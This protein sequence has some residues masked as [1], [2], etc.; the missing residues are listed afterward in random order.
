MYIFFVHATSSERTDYRPKPNTADE[1]HLE[2]VIRIFFPSG[3]RSNILPFTQQQLT[4]I[5]HQNLILWVLRVYIPFKDGDTPTICYLGAARVT[6]NV[7][8]EI[9]KQKY[10]IPDSYDMK[11]VIE[12]CVP[13]KLEF[14]K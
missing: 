1:W 9:E 7:E 13:A 14:G 12:L 3:N 8:M 2:S 6:H 4:C 11:L 5:D 10:E